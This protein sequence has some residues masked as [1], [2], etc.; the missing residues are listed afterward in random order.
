MQL[1]GRGLTATLGVLAGALLGSPPAA[2]QSEG[3]AANA[4]DRTASEPGTMVADTAVLIY[5]ED[6]D[7]VRAVE[8]ASTITWNAPGGAVVSGRLTYDALTG[9][10]PN[11]GIRSRYAQSF[12][13][14][15]KTAIGG[16]LGT[17]PDT[18]TG[19]SGRYTVPPGQLPVDKGF[20][21]HREA[22][23][24]G[25]TLPLA[26]GFKL[27]VG[28]AASFETDFTSWSTRASL[29]KDLWNKN[30]TLSVGF[31][32]EHDTVR[33]FT[34]IP[35]AQSF[36]GDQ[37]A[38]RSRVKRVASLVAGITQILSPDWLVQLNYSYGISRGY[39]TDP[40]KLFTLVDGD[41]GDPFY[42]I[43]EER[44]GVR[45]RSSIYGATK[46]ALGSSVTDASVRWYHD[47]WGI[48]ALTWSFSEHLPVGR[49]AYLEPGLRYYHQTAAR[50]FAPY[51]RVDE[52]TPRYLSAD[53]RLSRFRA[54]TVSLKAGAQLTPRLEIYGLVERYVQRGLRFDRSAPGV[55]AR[56]DLFAGTRST[57]V[58]SGLRYTWH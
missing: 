18:Q 49:A 10:T 5:Q 28:G 46:F 1:S 19:A 44:P 22:Y 26:D 6:D 39:H 25:V 36:M 34:G 12:Y 43:Y 21:D 52:P 2:A 27:S 31:N 57:S 29:A 17:N 30:T 45:R 56:T 4:Y 9:A 13:P 54:W 38:G 11:G 20:K 51:L 7:R 47:S 24:L 15:S 33:P 42:T 14:P 50:F 8:A 16:G 40:Y 41:T 35:R 3:A 58:I 53:S 48:T 37:I 32:F 55:L 23:D